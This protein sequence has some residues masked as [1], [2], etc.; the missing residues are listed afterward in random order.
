ML[1]RGER[2]TGERRRRYVRGTGVASAGSNDGRALRSLTDVLYRSFAKR[3]ASSTK[4]C[5]HRGGITS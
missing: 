3:S 1:K 4:S 2:A 5:T